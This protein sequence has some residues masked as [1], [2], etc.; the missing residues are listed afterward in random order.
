MAEIVNLADRRPVRRGGGNNK[1]TR[2]GFGSV[3][4][5]PSGRWQ[6]RYL[7][8]DDVEHRAPVRPRLCM[9]GCVT[10]CA[11][12]LTSTCK[13]WPCCLLPSMTPWT[14]SMARG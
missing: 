6:A 7:G 4:Q 10:C 11:A 9:P 1:G 8:P 3:R 2:R 12:C 13:G 5:L 14:P